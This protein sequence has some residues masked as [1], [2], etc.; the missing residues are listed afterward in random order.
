MITFI[1]IITIITCGESMFPPI[2]IDGQTNVKITHMIKIEQQMILVMLGKILH[3]KVLQIL[4]PNIFE[5]TDDVKEEEG[6]CEMYAK[7]QA[8]G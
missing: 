1:P 7:I 5:K 2:S 4:E 3:G 8:E 6:I